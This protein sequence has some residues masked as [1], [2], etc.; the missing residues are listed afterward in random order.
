M[1]SNRERANTI[2]LETEG[3][4]FGNEP[5]FMMTRNMSNFSLISGILNKSPNMGLDTSQNDSLD[6]ITDF[7][8]KSAR[9]LAC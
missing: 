7:N 3:T 1:D 8:K 5:V 6:E 4:D 9:N 2:N